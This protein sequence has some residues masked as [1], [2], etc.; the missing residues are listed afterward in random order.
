M[1][2]LQID[3]NELKAII[4]KDKSN[5]HYQSLEKRG[6]NIEQEFYQ[7]IDGKKSIYFHNCDIDSIS[8]SNIEIVEEL[9]FSDCHTF[10]ISI[11]DAK[12]FKPITFLSLFCK[13]FEL[14]KVEI[15]NTEIYDSIEIN[16]LNDKNK[17]MLN[18]TN[19]R[20]YREDYMNF[21]KDFS[22]KKSTLTYTIIN[23]STF[24][25][26]LLFEDCNCQEV[27]IANKDTEYL[28]FNKCKIENLKIKFGKINSLLLYDI[29]TPNAIIGYSGTLDDEQGLVSNRT[30]NIDRLR[31][32]NDKP[33]KILVK[34]GFIKNLDIEGI[35]HK[36]SNIF[37]KKVYLLRLHLRYINYGNVHFQG[38]KVI[39]PK[40]HK[41]ELN[42]KSSLSIEGADLGKTNFYFCELDKFHF[43]SLLGSKISDT[44]FA[45]SKFPSKITNRE[46]FIYIHKR[47]LKE[48]FNDLKFRISQYFLYHSEQR[49]SYSQLK[50]LFDNR[51]DNIQSNYYYA[52]EMDSYAISLIPKFYLHIP[53]LFNILLNKI[54][55]NHGKSW[56]QALIV[57]LSVSSGLFYLYLS[58]FVEPLPLNDD[59]LSFFL[60]FINPIHKAD[61]IA[62]KLYPTIK[63]S[64]KARWI[65]GVSRIIIS[66]LLYQLVQAF[67][68]NGR[69]AS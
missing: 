61:Y 3:Q 20:G 53:E 33:F 52:K 10:Y 47:T 37:I 43:F 30:P 18:I 60:E 15:F 14:I 64:G 9:I 11:K 57:T 7:E 28:C 12:I 63:I 46:P 50:K 17:I 36:D 1:N 44:F 56:I 66:Y 23:E 5:K 26:G 32:S 24:K 40:L 25:K 48:K 41:N 16:R 49:V 29:E 54:S 4:A 19:C 55:S 21:E 2:R 67:R 8:L 39:P 69:K 38:L 58:C 42:Q 68:K 22:I 45:G 34:S 65:E 27:E 13:G 59:S 31:I 51:G 35:I 62:E 6:V